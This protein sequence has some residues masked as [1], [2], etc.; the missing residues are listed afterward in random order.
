MSDELARLVQATRGQPPSP[1]FRARLRDQIVAV[2]E[3]SR[4]GAGGDTVVE[5]HHPPEKEPDR[6]TSVLVE[7]GPVVDDEV[8]ARRTR[9]PRRFR[10]LSVAAANLLLA[11][12]GIWLIAQ[13]D[14]SGGDDVPA[15]APGGELVTVG[16]TFVDAGAYRFDTLGTSFGLDVDETTGVL[17]NE[18][19]V[20][21]VTALTSGNA[22]D[23]TITFRR[24]GLLPDPAAPTSRV[25]P[26]S[27][28]P[29]ED[30]RGWLAG[31]GD[32]VVAGDPTATTLGGLDATL[33]E[34][35][36]PCNVADCAAGDPLAVRDLPMFTPGSNYRLWIVDQAAEDPLVVIVAVGD[37][38]L[39]WFDEAE[40]ILSS[41]EFGSIEPNPVRRL[42]AGVTDLEVFDGIRV[43]LT[44]DVTVVEPYDGF[45]RLIPP[46][47]AG[48]VE[49]LTRPLDS[50]GVEVTTT[51]QL[52]R[53][54][55]A[56]AVDLTESESLD[57]GGLRTR[58]FDVASGPFPNIVLKTR[59]AELVQ[60]DFGWESP[61][62]GHIW[63]VEHP[64][65]GLL[66]VSAERLTGPGPTEPLRSW[67]EEVLR[68]LDFRDP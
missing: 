20:V 39:A 5:R 18:N 49:L 2:T 41:V 36:F 68:S 28:W 26:N 67:T 34:L 37:G 29:A 43:E 63:V 62:A 3:G 1:E 23:R 4:P 27:G 47:R 61:Q 52:V 24:T 50:D 51:E 38:D 31:L 12:I 66:I 53:L 15:Q 44:E 10:L 14:E 54:L 42:P 16:N 55:D 21:S 7:V 57:I 30:L 17:L 64:E 65:R 56:E 59:A 46:E 13:I 33:V 40:A 19:G 9:R 45:A 58:A 48:D 60:D 35:E 6:D 25:D 32:D 11:G 22:D 8:T